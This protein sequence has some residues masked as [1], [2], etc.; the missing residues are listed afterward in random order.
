MYNRG[1]HLYPKLKM[2]D[3]PK[4]I[5]SAVGGYVADSLIFKD[6]QEH[7][8]YENQK[9]IPFFK[10]Q[11]RTILGNNEN[12]DPIR[13]INYIEHGGYAAAE[14]ILTHLDPKYI[15]DEVLKS[16]I[17]GRGR[18]RISNR[19]KSGN[20]HPN[21][22]RIKARNILSVMPMKA[23]PEPIWTGVY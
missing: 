16:G 4:V 21:L 5:D 19:K 20:S 6:F 9:D 7:K 14:K 13:I 11:T 10:K 23:I 12:L 2:D 15:I 3:I 1:R 18:S 17:R 22:V 8:K